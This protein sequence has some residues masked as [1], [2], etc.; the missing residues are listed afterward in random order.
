MPEYA[1]A[2]DQ[3]L[4]SMPPSKMK[5]KLDQNSLDAN[6]VPELFH[7]R[8]RILANNLRNATQHDRALYED[9]AAA[10]LL[11]MQNGVSIGVRSRE[12]HLKVR[13]GM[14]GSG[15]VYGL[16]ISSV[17]IALADSFAT[18]L[19]VPLETAIEELRGLF[20]GDDTV[21]SFAEPIALEHWLKVTR[22]RWG[23]YPKLEWCRVSQ[24]ADHDWTGLP[25]RGWRVTSEAEARNDL[26]SAGILPDSPAYPSRAWRRAEPKQ[27]MRYTVS[28]SRGWKAYHDFMRSF[29]E[30]VFLDA[31][32]YDL[33]RKHFKELRAEWKQ[34]GEEARR[35]M[36]ARPPPE[37]EDII[38]RFYL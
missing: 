35:F 25:M 10:E 3:L 30:G 31:D 36:K 22:D 17:H 7:G 12:K 28:T 33:A 38:R 18:A 16:N 13:G 15:T 1:Q 21:H 6:L 20:D 26:V 5:I 27:D 9:R 34:Q 14:T 32:R 4:E 8:A 2:Y 24:H 37:R 23:I 29:L 19:N 11:R